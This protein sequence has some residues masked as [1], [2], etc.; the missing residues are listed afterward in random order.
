MGKSLAELLQTEEVDSPFGAVDAGV[1]GL[2]VENAVYEE[3][4]D[5]V[6]EDGT[7]AAMTFTLND[8]TNPTS[9]TRAS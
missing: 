3:S 1:Y 7:T 6:R 2:T 5:I 8:A 4:R 9:I